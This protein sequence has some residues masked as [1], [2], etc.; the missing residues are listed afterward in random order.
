MYARRIS[1][2]DIFRDVP[3][4]TVIFCL[5]GQTNRQKVRTKSPNAELADICRQLLHYDTKNKRKGHLV[6]VI[7]VLVDFTSSG[8]WHTHL[9]AGCVT[10]SA[11]I[12]SILAAITI[13]NEFKKKNLKKEIMILYLSES[14]LNTI[15]KIFS[16]CF[17]CFHPSYKNKSV[18]EY[19][20]LTL[21]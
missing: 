21:G 10:S 8:L 20:N 14:L 18:W 9:W 7:Q 17:K 13:V 1:R 4:I 19:M 5:I 2:A 15:I 12:G 6:N 16:H 11:L 3:Y